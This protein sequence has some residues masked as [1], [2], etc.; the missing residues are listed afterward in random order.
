MDKT[1]TPIELK[2]IKPG[3]VVRA[4]HDCRGYTVAITGKVLG[5]FK[6]YNCIVFACDNGCEG[7]NSWD[8]S[9]YY[10]LSRPEKVI[11]KEDLKLGQRVRIEMQDGNIYTGEVVGL[12]RDVASGGRL[13][14]LDG[15]RRSGWDGSTCRIEAIAKVILLS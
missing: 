1:G 10:L 11:D 8:D 4:E 14:N 12:F 9:T 7:P 3:D 6:D 2:D 15:P 5:R 13:V